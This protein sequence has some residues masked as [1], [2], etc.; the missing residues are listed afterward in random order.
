[1]QPWRANILGDREEIMCENPSIVN[2][3][4]AIFP[5]QFHIP[6]HLIL[7][8]VFYVESLLVLWLEGAG[9][10]LSYGKL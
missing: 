8:M 4:Y 7:T 5:K 3:T 10:H 9:D 2:L 1:M 6:P